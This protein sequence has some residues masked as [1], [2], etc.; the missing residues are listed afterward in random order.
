MCYVFEFL[1]SL[2]DYEKLVTVCSLFN[3]MEIIPLRN[4]VLTPAL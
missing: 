2:L 3:E 4:M 1:L